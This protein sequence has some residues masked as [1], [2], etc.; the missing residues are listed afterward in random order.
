M[1]NLFDIK[2]LSADA[3]QFEE[4]LSN[5]HIKLERIV[6]FGHPTP[7]GEWYDQDETEWVALIKGSATLVYKDGLT[8]EMK[9]GD[10][11]LIPPHLQHR[12][13]SVSEDAVWLGLFIKE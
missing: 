1:G 6:S 9:A 7:Q 2:G 8:T 3:E 4:L 13:E 11:L 5:T 12:V 10:T